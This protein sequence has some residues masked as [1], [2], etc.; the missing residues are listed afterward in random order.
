M[1][2]RIL[3]FLFLICGL[4]ATAFSQTPTTQPK[5]KPKPK[6]KVER[7]SAVAS[8]PRAAAATAWVDIRINRYTS[9]ATTRRLAGVLV[10]GGQDA[11]VKDLEKAKA[12]RAV[13]RLVAIE[14]A[15]LYDWSTSTHNDARD[16][17]DRAGGLSA[18][19]RFALAVA[20]DRDEH[21]GQVKS[22]DSLGSKDVCH[23][24]A[25]DHGTDN[26][27]NDIGE[28]THLSVF[29]HDHARNPTGDRTKYDP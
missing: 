5:P 9:N 7:F 8:L 26:A 29:A 1:T 20:Y 12:P 22:G 28:G 11:L 21:A 19:G 15:N 14:L 25:A 17:A 10:E 4:A 6:P 18:P 3:A 23:K 24:E 27:N 16:A 2:K 13:L